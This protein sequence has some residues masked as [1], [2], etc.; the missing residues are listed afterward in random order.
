MH[1]IISIW[2]QLWCRTVWL[3]QPVPDFFSS[4]SE[5]L[6][7]RVKQEC[8][9]DFQIC[10]LYSDIHMNI[11]MQ[12]LQVQRDCPFHWHLIPPHSDDGLINKEI[13]HDCGFLLGLCVDLVYCAS[14]SL[15]L[16]QGQ[17][18]YLSPCLCRSPSF[19]ITSH[20]RPT[21][22]RLWGAAICED[23]W[24]ARW[25]NSQKEIKGDLIGIM[26]WVH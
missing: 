8:N 23:G 6:C 14:Q 7:Y 2:L 26:T 21:P 12:W 17:A 25:G 10:S 9:G 11:N 3:Y 24:G 20:P 18:L 13:N 4:Q 1:L 15:T 16:R 19:S 22:P 5:M